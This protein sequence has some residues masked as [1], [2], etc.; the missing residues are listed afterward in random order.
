MNE[1]QVR[2][3]TID[4]SLS[5]PYTHRYT[6]IQLC[7]TRQQKLNFC[8]HKISGLLKKAIDSVLIQFNHSFNSK[9]WRK[10]SQLK[11]TSLLQAI[12]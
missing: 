2:R 9:L 12:I 5:Y 7:V 4:N 3:N 10:A 1:C 8:V 11:A 6:D